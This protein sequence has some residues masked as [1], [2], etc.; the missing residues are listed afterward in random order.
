[1]LDGT[2]VVARTIV[3]AGESRRPIAIT[4]EQIVFA[5][6][7]IGAE[8]WQIY[9]ADLKQGIERR[10]SYDAGDVEPIGI[11]DSNELR[12]L[13]ISSSSRAV[14]SSS[15][16]LS[17]YQNK[18][19]E[20]GKRPQVAISELEH[21]LLFEVPAAGKRG[22][23]WQPVSIEPASKYI[24]ARDRDGLNGFLLALPA[25]QSRSTRERIYRL[26][27]SASAKSAVAMTWHPIQV[28]RPDGV[29]ENAPVVSVQVLQEA[30]KA[31]WTNGSAMWTTDLLGKSPVRLGDETLVVSGDLAVDPTGQW[32]VFSTPTANRGLNLAA[33]HRSGKCLRNLT[34]IPGDE[35]EPAFSPNGLSLYFTQ[36]QS[37]VA[38]VARVAFATGSSLT[39]ECQ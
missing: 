3:T 1:M 16:L 28:N 18:F 17:E 38:N 32:V 21:E 7:R 35:F 24:F 2:P 14:R 36:S 27:F 4:D 23:V 5:S 10:V 6:R 15:R 19:L 31:L 20:T 12:R 30:G 22:T 37:G 9:E 8:R 26:R 25:A 34:E 39:S 13:L 33:V 29:S 11:I